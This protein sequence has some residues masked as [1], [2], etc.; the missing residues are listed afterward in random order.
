MSDAKANFEY[1]AKEELNPPLH[2]WNIQKGQMSLLVH[3]VD[4]KIRCTPFWLGSEH[5]IMQ[6]FERKDSI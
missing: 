4:I 6:F 3:F 5:L 2:C 1:G